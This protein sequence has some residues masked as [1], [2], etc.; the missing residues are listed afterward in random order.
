M[1]S[2]ANLVEPKANKKRKHF[3][4]DPSATHHVYGERNMFSTYVPVN[5]RNLIMGNSATSRVVGIGKVV[6]KMTFGKELVLT[7]VLHVPD[8]CKN[9]VSGSMLSKSGFKLVFES[10][11]FVFMKNGIVGKR[12]FITFIDDCTRYCYVYLLRSKDEALDVFKHYKNEVENQLS[13]KIKV[14][15]SDRGGDSGLP[16][17]L[18]GEAILSTNHI[19]NKIPHKNKDVTSYELWKDHKP[20]YKYLEVWGVWLK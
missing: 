3:G 20:S 14:I 13:R 1:E 4:E 19:L 18:W 5:G 6:L 11:K 8:I 12:Y 10:D 16:Q 7:Y 2:K 15:R 9:L 17:N